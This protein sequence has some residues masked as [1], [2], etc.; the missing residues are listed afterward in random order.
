MHIERIDGRDESARSN[1][2][3]EYG[4]VQLAP[5]IAYSHTHKRLE[6]R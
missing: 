6:K 5:G 1:E 2:S 4:E 3:A